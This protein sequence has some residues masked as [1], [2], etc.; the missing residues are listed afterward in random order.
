MCKTVILMFLAAATLLLVKDSQGIDIPSGRKVMVVAH[1]G[2]SGYAPENTMAAFRLA[3]EMGADML[4]L[5]VW[6]SADGYIVVM[7]DDTVD[8]TTNGAGRI[9]E[10]TLQQIKKL[11]A[12]SKLRQEFANEPVPTLEE[13]LAWAG[14]KILVNIEIKGPGCEEKIVELLK[15]HKM[16][17]KVIVTS[18]HHEYVAKIKELEPAIE[19]GALVSEIEDLKA[20]IENCRPNAI[21]PKYTKVTKN[22]VAEAH[23]IGLRMIV[24]TVNDTASMRQMIQYGVDGIITNYPDMLIKLMNKMNKKTGGKE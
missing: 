20:V 17:G 5:D 3:H 19:T 16:T 18:F 1:R 12:G 13:V 9:E 4:E 23:K 21:V 15:K 8:R 11:D 14:D 6:R 7:H 10:M 2:A 24:Y 22:Q